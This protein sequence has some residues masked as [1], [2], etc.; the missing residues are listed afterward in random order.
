MSVIQSTILEPLIQHLVFISSLC[1]E[2]VSSRLNS[3]HPHAE[4]FD[5]AVIVGAL[6]AG[7]VPVN[8]VRELCKATKP[9]ESV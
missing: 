7:Q 1:Y 8:V 2:Y 9:G 4:Y 6:S 5:V 3:L